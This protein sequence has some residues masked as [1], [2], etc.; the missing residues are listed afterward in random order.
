MVRRNRFREV[1]PV[2]LIVSLDVIASGPSAEEVRDRLL[3]GECVGV[4]SMSWGRVRPA[5]FWPRV[6]RRMRALA[7]RV[8]RALGMRSR[9]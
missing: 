7:A 1:E 8:L 4:S 3:A 6:L 5:P 2:E 9:A